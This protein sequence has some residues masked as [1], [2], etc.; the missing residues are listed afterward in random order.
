MTDAQR[1]LRKFKNLSFDEKITALKDPDFRQ[2]VIDEDIATV[3]E[4]DATIAAAPF[5][6]QLP[7]MWRR[8]WLAIKDVGL[9]LHIF[10]IGYYI[11]AALWMFSGQWVAGLITGIFAFLYVF[12]DGWMMGIAYDRIS[13][14]LMAEDLA[15]RLRDHVKEKR[16]LG[17][18][19]RP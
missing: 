9:G 17:G 2:L 12:L 1:T 8:L 14:D 18:S 13:H 11:F 3:H 16:A 6:P 4:I 10:T 19:T 5:V 15:R 7:S